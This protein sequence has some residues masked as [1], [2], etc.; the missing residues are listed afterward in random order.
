VPPPARALCAGCRISIIE[1]REVLGSFNARL[2]E[3]AVKRLTS[4]GVAFVKGSVKEVRAKEI[5][6]QVRQQSR[7]QAKGKK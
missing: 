7:A 5:V 3:Y 2:R 4:G 6:L 1:A